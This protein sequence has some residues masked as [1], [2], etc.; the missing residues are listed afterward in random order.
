L[1]EPVAPAVGLFT[2]ADVPAA[3][4]PAA[5][6]AAPVLFEDV[7]LVHESEI[8]LTELTWN[9]P[10]LA[11]LPWMETCWPSYC[12]RLELSPLRLTV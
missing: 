11:W 9:E 5:A 2:V 12:F 6:P 7:W 4:A 10:S 3:P 8:L 1:V